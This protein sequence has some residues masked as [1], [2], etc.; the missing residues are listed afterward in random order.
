MTK[1]NYFTSNHEDIEK[2]PDP[3]FA[4]LLMGED[5]DII[6]DY[7]CYFSN[8]LTEDEEDNL[9]Q[10]SEEELLAI[11]EDRLYNHV[12]EWIDDLTYN[13]LKILRE[14]VDKDRITA[15]ATSQKL[16][17]EQV[18]LID[19]SLCF[20]ED[21]DSEFIIYGDIKQA[22]APYLDSAIERKEKNDE[23]F[24]ETLF[25]G[26]VN[27]VGRIEEAKARDVMKTLLPQTGR[28]LTSEDVD[29]FFDH[30][31]LVKYHRGGYVCQPDGALFSQIED[32]F[33]WEEEIRDSVKPFYPTDYMDV[34]AHG[35]YPFFKPYRIEERAFYSF[36]TGCLKYTNESA[37]SNIT[38]Y[39]C[40]LQDPEYD[41]KDMISELTCDEK[42]HDATM[43]KIAIDIIKRFCNGI[44]KF[45]L[46]GNTSKQVR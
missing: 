32:N 13:D 27:I 8:Y 17:I 6:G 22:V 16:L 29:R 26:I 34:L 2:I 12:E 9:E 36:L 3:K 1:N 14:L 40:H 25:L 46:K 15:P 11:I 42:F 38:F 28:K 35:E 10:K 24:L 44:P 20:E 37:L 41:I 23:G 31:M 30:S 5:L 4:E 43:K 18:M 45:K 7:V 39:Y 33:D 19:R 21:E